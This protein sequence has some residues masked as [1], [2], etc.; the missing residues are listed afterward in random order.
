MVGTRLSVILFLMVVSDILTS[1]AA[2][3][4][5]EGFGDDSMS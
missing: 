2:F 5:Y 1:L 3:V 4:L